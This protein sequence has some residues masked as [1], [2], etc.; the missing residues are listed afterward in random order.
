MFFFLKALPAEYSK[1]DKYIASS[2]FDNARKTLL[3]E[4]Y[5]DFL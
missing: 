5:F 1:I 2:A 4:T 3:N